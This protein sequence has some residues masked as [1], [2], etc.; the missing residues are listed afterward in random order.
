MPILNKGLWLLLLWVLF[1]V[2]L[3]ACQPQNSPSAAQPE[4]AAV[5]EQP[6]AEMTTTQDDKTDMLITA[7][8]HTARDVARTGHETPTPHP[9]AEQ[10]TLADLLP[11]LGQAPELTNEEWINSEPLRMSDLR[12]KVVLVEFWTFG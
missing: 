10:Q 3:V 1:M 6:T 12:G 4:A 2:I 5:A 8:T 11:N 7:A 9:T